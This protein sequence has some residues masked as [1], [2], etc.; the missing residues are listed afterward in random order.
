MLGEHTKVDEA[1]LRV[2]EGLNFGPGHVNVSDDEVVANVRSAVRR[3]V[4]QVKPGPMNHDRIALV[5]GGPSLEATLPE[6]RQAIFEGAKLVTLNGAYAWCVEHNLQPKCQV[7]LDARASNARFVDPPVPGCRYLIASQA[8]PD[9]WDAVEGRPQV[10]MFHSAHDDNPDGPVR[11]V[12]D[13][14]F[15]RQWFP[16]IGGTTVATRALIL[17][18][19]MGFVRYDLF[20]IDSCVLEGEHHAYPQPENEADRYLTVEASPVGRDDLKK[21]FRCTAWHLKQAED[22]LQTVRVNGHHFL[23]NVHGPGLIAYLM[24]A[25]AAEEE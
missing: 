22:F 19:T 13:A 7:V 11:Q 20:G 6:L 21:R 18:R 17:L 10:W 1:R 14:A 24:H 4:P 15:S 23:I 12:L 8:H 16:I 25:S 5:G 2:I 9:T 3:M